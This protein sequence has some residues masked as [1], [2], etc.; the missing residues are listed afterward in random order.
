MSA[1]RPL[2][3]AVTT[4]F[5]IL[6]CLPASS[7]EDSAKKKNRAHE[8]L[9]EA[10]RL[11]ADYKIGKAADKAREALKDDEALAEAH[12]YL[13]L[14]RFRAGDL[15]GAES[16]FS[17]ALELDQYQP[18]AHCQLGF[19]LYQ[20]GQLDTATDHWTLSARLDGTSPQALAGLAL[21]QFKNGQQDDALKTFEKVLM[22]DRRFADPAFVAGDNGPKWV[23][24]LLTD[25]RALQA[26]ANQAS[27]R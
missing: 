13:G 26:A 5:L 17:R 14:E 10:R 20:K 3:L 25:F 1:S 12:V 2:K 27:L 8:H 19:V 18:A 4:G 11:A 21:A 7:G 23:D 15:K 22:Y 16:E 9:I 24:P 6:I